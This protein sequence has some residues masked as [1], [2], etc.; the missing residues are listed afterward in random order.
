MLQILLL[1]ARRAE[2]DFRL[3]GDDK[4]VAKYQEITAAIR[5][6][7]DVSLL[8]DATKGQL[9]ETLPPYEAIFARTVAEQKSSGAAGKE[10]AAEL[11]AKAHA[12]EKIL[13]AHYVPDIWRNYLFAR[14][15]EKDYLLRGDDKYVKKL[16]ESVD[17]VRQ[18]VKDSMLPDPVKAEV[19]AIL[20]AYQAAF[21]ELVKEDARIAQLTETMRKAVHRIEPIIEQATKDAQEVMAATSRQA[22]DA[23]EAGSRLAMGVALTAMLIGAFFAWFI[24]RLIASS[25]TRMMRFVG[26][27][28]DGDLTAVCHISGRDEFGRMSA[29]LNSSI[30]RLR[31]TFQKVKAAAIQVAAGSAELAE[32]SQQMAEGSTEQAASIEETSAAMEEMASSIRQNTENAQTTEAI[33]RGAANEAVAGGKAVAEAVKAMKEIAEKISIIEEI[34]RQTNLLALNAA[35]EAAR[36][37]EHGKG[38]AVVAAEV[39]KLAER[40]QTAA[41]EIGQLSSSS[42]TVAEKAGAIINRLVPDI[43]KTAELVQEIASASGEQDQGAGQINS[44][45]QQLDQVIQRNAGSSEEMAATAEELSSQAGLLQEASSF[46]KVDDGSGGIITARKA[47]APKAP[48]APRLLAHASRKAPITRKA[49]A[50]KAPGR[51][52]GASS[53]A[54][55]DG[56]T[57]RMDSD[58]PT[59]DDFDRF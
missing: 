34:A 15:H 43:Q 24:G 47:P 49:S 33:S 29:T 46:F 48:Q 7:I 16:G 20:A 4:Y 55:K 17:A 27:L 3:R 42:V 59:D 23:V 8:A 26:K 10:T 41:G 11:S 6:E 19:T 56:V 5:T 37:G 36:A 39:R 44:A 57:L 9:R 30:T 54:G 50:P 51:S 31:E 21:Q 12:V 2:K 14:R 28:G 1:Q 22:S 13:E 45:I 25:L 52:T 53:P 35:I 38:F 18:A 40:S 58:P 32:S